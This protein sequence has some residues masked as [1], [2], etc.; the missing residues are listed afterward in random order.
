M[1]EPQPTPEH[2]AAIR[3]VYFSRSF[4]RFLQSIRR[5]SDDE[6]IRAVS[7][8]SFFCPDM[9][10][11]EMRKRARQMVMNLWHSGNVL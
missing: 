3:S 9:G 11:D 1:N 10:P 4:T 2:L 6:L 7:R 5:L 8:T